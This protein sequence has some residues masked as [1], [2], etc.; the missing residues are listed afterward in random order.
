MFK[1][2]S[3]KN[4]SDFIEQ[5]YVDLF[6]SY[7]N[8]VYSPS[9]ININLRSLCL[10]SFDLSNNVLLSKLLSKLSSLHGPSFIGLD[11]IPG[12]FSF[13]LRHTIAFPLWSL[14]RHSLDSGTFHDLWKI[15]SV[16]LIFK[17]GNSSN[18]TNY[19]PVTMLFHISEM[20][21]SLVFDCRLC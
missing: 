16:T 3:F 14:F 10:L 6:S 8:F 12:D 13:Y 4:L 18:D 9:T 15:C 11:S 7:F 20:F 17:L 1:N 5:E 2:I 21:E 19:C